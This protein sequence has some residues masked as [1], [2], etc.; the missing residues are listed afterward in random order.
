MFLIKEKSKALNKFKIFKIQVEKQLGKL[1]KIVR[2]DCEGE[3]YGKHGVSG[4]EKGPFAKY[5]ESCRIIAQFTMPG[6]PEQNGVAERRNRTLK[7]MM[8]S[9]QSRTN[10]PEYLW[11]EAI[12]TALYILNRIPSKSVPK[13]PFE[14]WKGW[15]PSLN[16]L[17]VWGCPSEVRL[18]NPHESKLHARSTRCYFIGYPDHSKGY[19][20]YC[21]EGGAR[22]VESQTAKFLEYD[23]SDEVSPSQPSEENIVH[24]TVISFPSP[25]QEIIVDPLPVANPVQEQE[26]IQQLQ[27]EV[28]MAQ[29]NIQDIQLRRSTRVRRSAI[30]SDYVVYLGESDYDI[31]HVIDPVKFSDVVTSPQSDLWWDA[32]RDE[33]QSMK[34]NKVWELVELPE[35]CKPV[36]CKW[37]YKTKR[38]S[39][40]KIER[41]KARLVAKGFTQREGIDFNVTFSPVSTKDAFRVIMALVAHFDME[42]HQ[43]DVK[44]AFLNGDLY[45]E[46]YMEQPEGFKEDDCKHLVCKLKK[47][48]YGLKQASRQWYLKFEE[49]ITSSGF[50][51]NKV[52]RCVY[53]KVR[54][55]KIIFLILYVDDVLLASNDLDMLHEVK[56]LLSMHFDMKDLGEAS[57]VLGIEIHRDRSRN[58]LG[59]SQKAYIERVLQR[60]N[61]DACKPCAAPI[62]HGEKLSL[63]QCPKN[64]FE[65]E[66]MKGIPYASAV[67]SLM[68]AQVCTRP[69]IAFVV[70]LLGRY[71]SNPGMDHWNVVKR[72]LRYLKGTKDYMLTYRKVENLELIGY[73]DS[74][75]AMCPDDRKSTSGYIFMLAGGAVSWKSVKQTLV[76]SSTMHAEF[77]ACY[78]A[79][80]QAVWLRNLISDMFVVD[81]IARPIC[82]YCDNLSAVLFSNNNKNITG[83]KHLEVKYLTI[84]ELV[85]KCDITIE[86]IRTESM[87][88]DPL[89]KGLCPNVFKGHVCNMGIL[90]SFDFVC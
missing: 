47:S 61:M 65:R 33:M 5:L 4:Q 79:S 80:S 40:G 51:E 13:T 22:I 21:R 11:G 78:G 88:A 58:L 23:V 62:S 84:K 59:L 17:R 32:M 39:K 41:F 76:T 77:V 38:D 43:M 44:T 28:P 87:L 31:G 34:H 57:F 86:H 90:E 67:G 37:I 14:L 54:G 64:E 83:S 52:E 3:Y 19:R 73:T 85:Q 48:I 50:M 35:G 36:G 2:S 9:M 89:T 24:T 18:Y 10:L 29:D 60:F 6:S 1:I 7:D 82:V 16:H 55:S 45:E 30:S 75:F 63:A 49:V 70:G 46:V 26:P 27:N 53:H 42:L 71:L 12:K 72:V 81:S 8:R 56:Q 69:D 66:P 20:F 74:D 25:I 68:Y 15:K